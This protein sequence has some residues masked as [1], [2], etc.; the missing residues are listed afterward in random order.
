MHTETNLMK[1]GLETKKYEVEGVRKTDWTCIEVFW[2]APL[3][4][5]DWRSYQW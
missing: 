2:L 3:S 5:P 4:F 1:L